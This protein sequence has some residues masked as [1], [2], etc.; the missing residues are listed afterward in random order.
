MAKSKKVTKVIKGRVAKSRSAKK[1]VAE[2]VETKNQ[3]SASMLMPGMLVSLRTSIIGNADYDKR[4]IEAPH[5]LKG[6][7]EREKWETI[8][9]IADPD[10]WKAAEV[11]RS[12]AT[13]AIRTP[14][15]KSAFG[16]LCPKGNLPALQEGIV[17]AREAVEA[18]NAKAK[19]TRVEVRVLMGEIAQNDK[20]AISAINSEMRD[21]LKAMQDGIKNLDAPA[22][23]DAANRARSVGQMLTADA[24]SKVRTAIEVARQA[25][26]EIVKAGDT[27]AQNVD[28]AAIRAIETNRMAFIDVG[29]TTSKVAKPKGRGR[30][31][32][33]GPITAVRAPRVASKSKQP[34]AQVEA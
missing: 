16:L 28:K 3:L 33:I 25:A 32:D 10:E 31:V 2:P 19:L 1:V 27:A 26:K 7:Q 23:R 9:T 30:V 8:K 4:E 24:Q 17:K 5:R 34:P 12:A 11:A 22:I 13:T 20:E 21:L 15:A 29:Q 6:G 18:F 14:C